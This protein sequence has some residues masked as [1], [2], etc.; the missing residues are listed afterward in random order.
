[1]GNPNHIEFAG[2]MVDVPLPPEKQTGSQAVASIVAGFIV[3]CGF[4]LFLV[5]GLLFASLFSGCK[6]LSESEP[7][8]VTGQL[9]RPVIVI[10]PAQAPVTVTAV[11][12]QPVTVAA[13]PRTVVADVPVT[14]IT[15]PA[16]A[17]V[18][19]TAVPDQPVTVSGIPREPV[20]VTGQQQGPS[21]DAGGIIQGIGD[22]L[23]AIGVP[24]ATLLTG[25]AGVWLAT[26]RKRN[27]FDQLA[28][29]AHA[30]IEHD[31][32]FDAEAARAALGIKGRQAIRRAVQPRGTA[33]QAH[34]ERR[35]PRKT[36]PKVS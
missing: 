36:P 15:G 22:V 8:T 26:R 23:G 3:L 13:P 24:G 32:T 18:T 20:T 14:T 21:L 27:A 34:A 30:A 33:T 31:E 16:Q 35:R 29:L 12:A 28:P 6:L 11:P 4:V 5:A 25:A 19:V 2:M 10:G 1:M 17:P 7:V 9:D